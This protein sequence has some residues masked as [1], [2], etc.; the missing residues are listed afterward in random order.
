[1][2]LSLFSL[3]LTGHIIFFY[4]S[5]KDK[6][7]S[8]QN[9]EDKLFYSFQTPFKSTTYEIQGISIP[10]KPTIEN[11]K[12]SKDIIHLIEQLYEIDKEGL[13]NLYEVEYSNIQDFDYYKEQEGDE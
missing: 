3:I 4:S 6:A 10:A 12:N 1:M 5:L 11:R 13:E 7:I 9:L 8:E 2:A